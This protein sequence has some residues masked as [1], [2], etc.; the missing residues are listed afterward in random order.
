MGKAIITGGLRFY[1]TSKECHFADPITP[2]IP[3]QELVDII[4]IY[5]GDPKG[6]R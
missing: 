6:S 2:A 3:L 4:H 1:E 5:A